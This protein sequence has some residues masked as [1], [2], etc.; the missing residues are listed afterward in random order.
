L[1]GESDRSVA[2][3]PWR[4]WA[5]AAVP[6]AGLLELG[7][8]VAQ[9]HEV[10]PERDWQAAR[11]YVA[12]Q[13]RP[14]DLIAFAP[15]WVDPVGRE[16]FGASL[17]TIE[18]EARAD[19][20][21]FPRALEVS[22]RGAHVPALAEWHR[23]AQ[24]RFGSVTVFTLDNPA[25]T[26]VIDD[27]VSMVD[28]PHLRV[29]VVEGDREQACPY[30]R[31]VPQTGELGF[32]T[33]VPAD[34]FACPNSSFVG[35]S[36][37]ED[38]EYYPRRCIDAPPQAGNSLLRLR[39]GDVHFGRKLVGHH[40]LYI[41]AELR[42]LDLRE[43]ISFRAGDTPIGTATHRD[44]QGWTPFEFDTGALA[45]TEGELTVDIG[46]PAGERRMYCFEATTR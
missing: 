36:I 21:R 15:R 27:L 12:A 2:P 35:V 20:S 8:H 29:S 30:V 11:A 37:V 14:P 40:A 32:G 10:T 42:S 4:R 17:A 39:Y 13:I 34:R 16:M 19:E 24:A 22:I 31:A 33:A 46:A 25:P 3:S 45:G 9:T 23:T 5:F 1:N 44:G 43:G 18:R 7:A 26:R 28:P 41:E 6:A 38:M